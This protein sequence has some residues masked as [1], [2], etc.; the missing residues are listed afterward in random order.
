MHLN[1][2]FATKHIELPIDSPL[3]GF[4]AVRRCDSRFWGLSLEPAGDANQVERYVR[5]IDLEV[6]VAPQD[7]RLDTLACPGEK[8][9]L[10]M[11]L[12]LWTGSMG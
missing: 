9:G 8:Q 5:I 12:V 6:N 11:G 1:R 3:T 7:V 10:K 2:R 4:H